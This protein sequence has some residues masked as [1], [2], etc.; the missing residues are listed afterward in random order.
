MYN[1]AIYVATPDI[2]GM[3]EGKLQSIQKDMM[4]TLD[5]EFALRIKTKINN[6]ICRFRPRI[7]IQ[8]AFIKPLLYCNELKMQKHS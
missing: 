2:N 4:E 6:K 8:V 5:I 7:Q 1:V 3:I